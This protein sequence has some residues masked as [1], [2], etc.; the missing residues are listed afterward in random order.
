MDQR[1]NRLQTDKFALIS[2]FWNKFVENS[3]NSSNQEH[4]SLPRTILFPTKS[5]CRFTQYM[6]NKPDKFGIKSWLAFDVIKGF[7]FLGKRESREPSV[8]LGEFV[9]LKLAEMYTAR[10]V[11]PLKNAALWDVAT[12][13]HPPL[14]TFSLLSSG[15]TGTFETNVS[16]IN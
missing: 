8:P 3:Q 10:A 1:N 12:Y 13:M 7:P 15:T 6:P 9:A 16:M 14:P 11:T 2:K 4:I 5:R